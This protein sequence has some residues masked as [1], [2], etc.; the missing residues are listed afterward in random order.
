MGR[1]KKAISRTY[2]PSKDHLSGS[3]FFRPR[4]T[5]D[6][7]CVD[8]PDSFD[9]ISVR[10]HHDQFC[11][12]SDMDGL[13]LHSFMLIS[14][15]ALFHVALLRLS[16]ALLSFMAHADRSTAYCRPMQV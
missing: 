5:R 14:A 13:C 1:K 11:E 7:A 6:S 9:L 15:E 10:C 12:Y 4:E 16:F 3:T 8:C 2:D